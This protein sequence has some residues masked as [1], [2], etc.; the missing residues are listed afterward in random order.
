MMRWGSWIFAVAG[1]LLLVGIFRGH[2]PK[3]PEIITTSPLPAALMDQDYTFQFQAT[4]TPPLIWKA[5]VL[6]SW[7]TL[8]P[9]GILHAHP[10]KK[11]G[12]EIITFTVTSENIAGVNEHTFGLPVLLGLPNL[13]LPIPPSP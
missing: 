2:P 10:P 1:V 5:P 4:G 3:A 8:S 9:T 12:V 13:H 7:I 6:P 11:D